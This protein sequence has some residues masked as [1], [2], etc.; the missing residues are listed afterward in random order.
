VI[1]K[2]CPFCKQS[3]TLLNGD[4]LPLHD[5]AKRHAS[6]K[7]EGSGLRFL[8]ARKICADRIGR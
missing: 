3:V 1:A 8:D 2:I 5:V 4:L 6:S 7:C